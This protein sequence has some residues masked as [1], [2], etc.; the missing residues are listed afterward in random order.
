VHLQPFKTE[1]LRLVAL[2]H[3]ILLSAGGPGFCSFEELKSARPPAV[4]YDA[5]HVVQRR[6]CLIN[7]RI[8]LAP[9]G[10]ARGFGAPYPLERLPRVPR[11]YD[12]AP[13]HLQDF[14]PEQR[15]GLL[16]VHLWLQADVATRA[17]DP[18]SARS[19]VPL[20]RVLPSFQELWWI[21]LCFERSREE[22]RS[23]AAWGDLHAEFLRVYERVQPLAQRWNSFDL[24]CT[25][26]GTCGIFDGRQQIYDAIWSG[27]AQVRQRVRFMNERRVLALRQHRGA[28][29]ADWTTD[30]EDQDDE[31]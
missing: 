10:E 6:V 8:L 12:Q 16:C 19:S 13:G 24:F 2:H 5:M 23:S 27:I 14:T 17:L 30:E 31:G 3:P 21:C 25:L 18:Q 7:Q 20:S 11:G 28:H 15:D 9:D 1:Y 22:Q 29:P 4:L 26:S